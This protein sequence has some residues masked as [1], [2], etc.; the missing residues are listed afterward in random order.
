M[1]KSEIKA[2]ELRIKALRA[3]LSDPTCQRF[4]LAKRHVEA[5]LH[6]EQAKLQSA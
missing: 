1:T 2:V 4:P 5:E 3:E 6:R